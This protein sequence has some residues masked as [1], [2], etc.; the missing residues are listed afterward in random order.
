MSTAAGTGPIAMAD[1]SRLRVRFN[2]VCRILRTSHATQ[3]V[4]N[5]YRAKNKKGCDMKKDY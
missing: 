2:L 1:R 5:D 4:L 3:C